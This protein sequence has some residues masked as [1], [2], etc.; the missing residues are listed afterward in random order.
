MELYNE[1][2]KP[3]EAV[4]HFRSAMKLLKENNEEATL[5]ELD[6]IRFHLEKSIFYDPTLVQAHYNLALLDYKQNTL[7]LTRHHL[8]KV[9]SLQPNHFKANLMLCDLYVQ[10]DQNLNEAVHCYIKLLD[11][12]KDLDRNKNLSESKDKINFNESSVSKDSN[13]SNSH[14][15]SDDSSY[16]NSYSTSSNISSKN[17]HKESK[18]RKVLTLAQHNLCSVL[19][20]INGKLMNSNNTTMDISTYCTNSNLILSDTI[21]QQTIHFSHVSITST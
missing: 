20:L 19:D 8:N 6:K 7:H 2:L 5:N 13:F 14:L 18:D 10:I 15:N 3:Q 12:S 11:H 21:A 1:L 17:V 16:S 9:L 4:N